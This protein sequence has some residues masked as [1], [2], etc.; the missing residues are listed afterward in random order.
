MATDIDNA[1]A[2]AVKRM[3]EAR[4]VLTGL[5]SALELI[6]GHATKISC[7]TP[8]RRFH[9]SRPRGRCAAR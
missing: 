7:C 9:G 2:A 5:G 4:P 8:V 1:N 3:I 6:P